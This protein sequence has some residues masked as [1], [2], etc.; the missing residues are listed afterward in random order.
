MKMTANGSASI[1][2]TL[3]VMAP[4]AGCRGD[5]GNELENGGGDPS[6]TG[7]MIATPDIGLDGKPKPVGSMA[8]TSNSGRS[9]LRR[10]NRDEYRNTLRDLFPKATL[11]SVAA[12][13]DPTV[14]TF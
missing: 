9:P 11:P 14:D 4:L 3:L 7:G 12:K 10:L 2:A 5:I 13:V 8:C 6:T 1:F